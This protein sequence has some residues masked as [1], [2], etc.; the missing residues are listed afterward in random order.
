M[1]G[2]GSPG[3][4]ATDPRGLADELGRRQVA[5]PGQRQERRRDLLGERSDLALQGIDR[6]GQLADPD[7]QVAGEAGDRLGPIGELGLE[8]IE[9]A[10]A[11]ERTGRRLGDAELDEEPAEALLVAGPID[12]QVLPVVYEEAQLALEPVGRAVGRSGS[13]RAARATDRASI[14]SLL[15]GSRFERRA[16]AMSL[17]GTRTT[18]SPAAGRSRSRR[19]VRWR[20]S[21]KAH[22]RSRQRRAQ[23]R[24]SRCP[25]GAVDTVR[26]A[27]LRPVPSTAT[28]V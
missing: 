15:P 10:P 18:V 23:R 11:A 8:S 16:P 12:D 2:E 26:S 3:A 28:T 21:S 14:G 13:R 20:Q 9:D 7:E 6:M 17:G 27:S 24:S 5:A 4:E 19:R 25:A 1:P 22:V